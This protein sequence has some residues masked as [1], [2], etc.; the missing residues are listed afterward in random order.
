MRG[1]TELELPQIGVHDTYWRFVDAAAVQERTALP[2]RSPYAV[3]FGSLTNPSTGWIS[4]TQ[5]RRFPRKYV[6][7]MARAPGG[8]LPPF[9]VQAFL[10]SAGSS[11]RPARYACASVVFAQGGPANSVFWRCEAIGGVARGQGGES[12]P[13]SDVLAQRRLLRPDHDVTGGVT[14]GPPGSPRRSC[15]GDHTR[16]NRSR[17]MTLSHAATKSRVN[18]SC[19]SAQA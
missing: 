17:F 4:M 15:R 10:D 16:S 14:A 6:N 19:E 13:C 18:F 3:S 11:R 1:L 2:S 9:D 5:R 7:E 12:L 8:A